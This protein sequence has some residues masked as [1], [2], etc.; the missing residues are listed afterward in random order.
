M[1]ITLTP[2]QIQSI[3][4]SQTDEPPLDFKGTTLEY[5]LHQYTYALRESLLMLTHLVQHIQHQ[6]CSRSEVIAALQKAADM[7]HEQAQ[8]FYSQH[9]VF[10]NNEDAINHVAIKPVRKPSTRKPYP[11]G[12]RSAKP[13]HTN[14]YKSS[15]EK[16]VCGNCGEHIMQHLGSEMTCP[17]KFKA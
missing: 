4:A 9:K 8:V 6:Q 17:S 15:D 5:F 2:S 3:I 1:Q 12:T 13:S 11:K 7:T 16:G 14:T 10:F